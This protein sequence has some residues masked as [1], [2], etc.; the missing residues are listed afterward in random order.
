MKL[1]F[2]RRKNIM[3]AKLRTKL[4]LAFVS[5]SLLPTIILF[6]GLFTAIPKPIDETRPNDPVT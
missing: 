1:L 4:V 2:E 3:G 5:L 6:F